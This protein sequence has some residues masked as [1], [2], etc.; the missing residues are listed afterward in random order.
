[1]TLLVTGGAGFIGSAVVRR[2]IADGYRVVN[3]DALTYAANLDN[4]AAVQRDPNYSFIHVDLRDRAA[5]EAAISEYRPDWIAHLA[6]ESHVDRSIDGPG[7]F[8][9]TNV[10]GT[11]NLLQAALGLWRRL[12]GDAARRFRLL[13]V[14]TDEVY[15]ALGPEGEFTEDTPF[16][17]NSP[18]SASKA[19]SDM[20]ARAWHRTYGLPVLISHCS[21]NYGPY[22]FPEK[23]LPVVILNALEGKPIPV[24]GRGE[25]VR[26]W[27]FVDDHADALLRILAAGRLGETYNIGGDAEARNIDLVE[28]L[29]TLMDEALPGSPHRPHAEL[30]SFVTDRPGH[31]FR[32]AIDASKIKT[33]L[34]WRPALDLDEG[35]KRTVRWYLDN[36]P[37]WQAIRARGFAGERLGLKQRLA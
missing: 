4:V 1:M 22:Q 18:Y 35:L 36:K 33:E 5:V 37:W 15:G 11:F 17:P 21:N 14:S 9:E 2:A 16:A 10:V 30:I 34:G 32:Y 23:L 26:D 31:D 20:L 25:N 29:C 3:L 12:E 13:H 24:Y 6:A 7:D 27:L 19:G 8:I 28:R